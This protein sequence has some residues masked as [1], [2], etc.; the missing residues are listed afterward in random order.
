MNAIF[1]DSD[2]EVDDVSVLEW[3]I[4]RDAVAD[5]LVY[6]GAEGF[7]EFVVV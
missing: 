7:G 1:V 5:D 6:G 3:T 4:V 2:I